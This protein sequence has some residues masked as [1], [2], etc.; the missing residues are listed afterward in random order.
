MKIYELGHV[1]LYVSNLEKVAGFYRDTLGFTEIH[2]GGGVAAFSG[3]RTHHELLL[4]EVGGV[5]AAAA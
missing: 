3:G 2:R 1:V 5:P 4:I